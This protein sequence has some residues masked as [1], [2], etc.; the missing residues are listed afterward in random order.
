MNRPAMN[1]RG[2]LAALGLAPVVFAAGCAGTDAP[3]T[4]WYELRAEPPEPRPAPRPG[5]GAVWR[6]PAWCACPAPWTG[7]C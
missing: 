1:R 2:L 3:P 6:S 4:R 5:N 7:T